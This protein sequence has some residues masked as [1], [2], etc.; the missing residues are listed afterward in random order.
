MN[1]FFGI[2]SKE[3]SSEIQVPKFQNKNSKYRDISLY[4]AKIN[5][6]SWSIEKMHN[7]K[8]NKNFFL[9][10]N[11]EISNQ[12][13]FFLADNKD[14]KLTK[15]KKLENFSKFTDT[16]PAF[17]CNFKIFVEKGGFSSF[18]SE[19]PYSMI[20]KKGSILSSIHSIA[21][22]DAEKNYVFVRNI[23]Q[24]PVTTNFNAYFVNIKN[25]TIEEKIE[26]KTNYTNSFEL[27]KSLIKPEI[28]LF[29]KDYI[30]I[31]MYV[32][33]DNKHIS[34]EH[35]HPPHE[36]ILSQNKYEL[37]KKIKNQINEIVS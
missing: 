9:L 27:S 15:Y 13:V 16:V 8:I 36:Y 11:D 12:D 21:N 14:L 6:H 37:V 17:R 20:T 19:Y 2:N 23:L 32:S 25:K 35:T 28:Y 7:D 4:R 30:G 33:V 34:F 24:D 29:T 22:K 1:F 5:D 26:L 10:K 31:P 18:Q 3:F